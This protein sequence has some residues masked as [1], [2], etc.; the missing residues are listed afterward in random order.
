MTRV[1]FLAHWDWVLFNFRMPIARALRDRGCEVTFVCPPGQYVAGLQEQGFR[2]VNW[3]FDRRGLNPLR[4]LS[5]IQQ[6]LQVYRTERPDVAHHFTIRPSLYGSMA[7]AATG[8]PLVINTFTGLGSLFSGGFRPA[9]ARLV[10]G[11]A[12]ARYF[13]RPNSW[14]VFQNGSDLELLRRRRWVDARRAR[15]IF[16]SGVDVKRFVHRTELSGASNGSNGPVVLMAARLLRD[17]G[18]AEF[19]DAASRLKE[20]HVTARFWVAGVPDEGNPASISHRQLEVWRRSGVVEFLGH[21]SDMPELLRQADIAVLP[22]YYP[23]GV[24]RFVLEAAATGLP[25]IASD[26][27]GC[28]LIVRDGVN[29]YLVPPRD[30]SALAE[31]IERLL[32]SQA[33]RG[34]F[35]Q[36]S[37]RMAVERFSE[38]VVV[39]QYMTL[40]REIG[41]LDE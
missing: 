19:V 39:K 3:P 21:R 18:V 25:L 28:Q 8:V 32:N 29:G 17:K 9:T 24:P 23:E 7:A 12:A 40:Y 5:A 20:K 2:W 11:L 14:A 38:E 6:L 27:P 36:A 34:R 30:V 41:A 22:S 15:V 26:I 37:R 13:R 33:L 4:Q 1:T 10:I 16:G 31:S 35:G